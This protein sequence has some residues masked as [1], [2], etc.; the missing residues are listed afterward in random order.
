MA[1]M[2]AKSGYMSAAKTA[3]AILLLLGFLFFL[4]KTLKQVNISVA[5]QPTIV[6]E[7]A[8]GP[9]RVAAQAYESAAGDGG[10]AHPSSGDVPPEEVAQ[11]LKKWMAES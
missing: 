1:S 7:L 3:G 5:P 8:A 6:Q 11:V 4:K 10:R 2:A 9:Q